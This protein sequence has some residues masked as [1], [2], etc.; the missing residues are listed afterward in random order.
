MLDSTSVMELAEE[1]GHLMVIGG[2][3]IGLEFGQMY[4]RF[5]SDVTIVQREPR[6]IPR[7]NP[8]V[9]EEVREILEEDG[10]RIEVGRDR[11]HRA[12]HGRRHRAH[13]GAGCRERTRVASAGGGGGVPTPSDSICG[14]A[15]VKG[16][17]AGYVSV[18]DAL[19]TNVPGIYA[20]GDIKGG[21]AFTHISYDDYRILETRAAQERRAIGER[22]VPYTMFID[23]QL[24]QHR[25][26]RDRS[27][28]AGTGH[29]GRAR[30]R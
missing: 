26:A 3:Y 22:L 30:C 25:P 2:G 20:L 24:G 13:F 28:R 19:R 1:P 6:M 5:G 14:A 29:Q 27:A 17:K 12:G 18:D 11:T 8:D 16:D 23:P 15:G 10:I 4:R 9:T 21:P 7:E